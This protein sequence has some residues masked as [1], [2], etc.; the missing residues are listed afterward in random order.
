MSYFFHNFFLLEGQT[1]NSTRDCK[2]IKHDFATPGRTFFF[3]GQCSKLPSF[4][5]ISNNTLYFIYK[6]ELRRQGGNIEYFQSFKKAGE[7]LKKLQ[8]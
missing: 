5:L 2:T 8:G 4:R 6:F 3:N 7:T 1:K